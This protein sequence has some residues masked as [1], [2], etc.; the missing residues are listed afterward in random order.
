[1]GFAGLALPWKIT[2]AR[3]PATQEHY[4]PGIDDPVNSG[5]NANI[6]ADAQAQT[7]ARAADTALA[8]ACRGGPS[9]G[10]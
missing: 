2:M 3:Q 7:H 4:L 9:G 1:M 6:P 8:E 5:P 10:V